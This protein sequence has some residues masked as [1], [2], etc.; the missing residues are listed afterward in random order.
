MTNDDRSAH[1]TR[2]NVRATVTWD[3]ERQERAV[4]YTGADAH[5]NT[6]ALAADLIETGHRDVII[7]EAGD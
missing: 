7:T 5:T 2:S 3:D 6:H 4:T 1:R